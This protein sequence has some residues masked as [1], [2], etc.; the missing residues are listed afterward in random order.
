M[1]AAQQDAES[2]DYGSL[3]KITRDYLDQKE[4]SYEEQIVSE[5]IQFQT[6]IGLENL[7]ARTYIDCAE[8]SRQ[9]TIFSYAPYKVPE[10]CRESIVEYL[11]RVNFRISAPRFE[12]DSRDGELRVT[13]PA[14]FRETIATV[15]VIGCMVDQS[16]NVLD[17]YLPGILMMGYG[18]RMPTEAWE[19]VTATD[20]QIPT[21]I[22]STAGERQ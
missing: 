11:T 22:D 6:R 17:Q 10:G 3:A 1:I 21:R 2:A 14:R 18:K 7:I 4:W 19:A 9:V 12:M 15:E 8:G 13:V 20:V 5:T 16:H